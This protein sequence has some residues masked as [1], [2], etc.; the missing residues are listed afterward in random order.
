MSP[1]RLRG[2]PRGWTV[3]PLAVTASQDDDSEDE[4][5]DTAERSEDD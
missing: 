2:R 1:S 5:D 3:Y 4:R